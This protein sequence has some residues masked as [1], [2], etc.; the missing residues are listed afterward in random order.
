MKQAR[1]EE[2]LGKLLDDHLADDEL[3]KLC[4]L[5]RDDPAL[6]EEVRSQLHTAELI[7]QAEDE[8]RGSPRFVA[9]TL[10]R[11]E[12][13]RFVAGVSA[14]LAAG[15]R[16]GRR[17]PLMGRW[18]YAAAMILLVVTA[19]VALRFRSE[20]RIARIS[21]LNGTILWIGDGGVV[22]ELE[23][24]MPLT[25]GTLDAR[26]SDAWV[27]LEFPDGSLATV[28]GPAMVTISD[29]GQKELYLRDGEL[30]A[31]V[32]RQARHRPMLIHTRTA[33][34][35]VLGTQLN[36]EAGSA[37]TR[38]SVNEGRVRLTRLVD[39]S[40]AEVPADHQIVARAD[41]TE[42][43][44]PTPRPAPVDRWQSN[45]QVSVGKFLPPAGTLPARLRAL[46][47][48]FNRP[49][50][51]PLAIY[52]AGF[53]VSQF[54]SPPVRLKPHSRFQLRGRLASAQELH[55]GITTK[56]PEGT[57]GGK[58]EVVI[59]APKLEDPSGGFDIEVRLG[60]LRPQKPWHP[61]SPVNFELEDCYL[62]TVDVEAGLEVFQVELLP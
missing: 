8:L 20:P 3:A 49:R 46:P 58:F 55:F 7:A 22:R 32:A 13:D 25:G 62:C 9:A 37:E 40:V 61:S 60:D 53:G 59:P 45:L 56:K 27:A 48:V 44:E 23:V 2:L 5:S 39:G 54:G 14:A 15:D 19:G 17:L 18:K 4:R 12:G 34:L 47:I 36:V 43:F 51:R 50:E 16:R 11:I 52:V 57:F 35:E 29:H 31:R 10:D 41:R 26:T 28:S 33:E 1:S 38:L 6:L 24:G 21:D 30:F 42:A